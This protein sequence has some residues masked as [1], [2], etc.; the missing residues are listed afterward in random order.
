MLIY[1]EIDPEIP[2]NRLL[3]NFSVYILPYNEKGEAYCGNIIPMYGELLHVLYTF[4]D[5]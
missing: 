5:I 4:A 2:L 1:E 3:D